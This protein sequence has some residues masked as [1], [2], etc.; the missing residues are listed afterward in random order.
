MRK[1]HRSKPSPERVVALSAALGSAVAIAACGSGT[2]ALKSG[3]VERSIAASIQ[4]QHGIHT[5]VNCPQNVA[6]KAGT[7]FTCTARLDVGAYPVH[8]TVVNGNGRVVYTN[9]EPLV[10]L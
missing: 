10:A 4:A 2:P 7:R 8:V 9:S 5:I 6:R 1:T 3:P